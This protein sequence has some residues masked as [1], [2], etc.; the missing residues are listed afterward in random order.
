MSKARQVIEELK[1]LSEAAL[2]L[3]AFTSSLE[4]VGGGAHE[5]E[6]V[7]YIF[8]PGAVVA[9]GEAF[10][11][12]NGRLRK[13]NNHVKDG[14]YIRASVNSEGSVECAEGCLWDAKAKVEDG[15]LVVTGYGGEGK[16]KGEAMVAYDGKGRLIDVIHDTLEGIIIETGKGRI[17]EMCANVSPGL[18]TLLKG[19][20]GPSI[21]R[22]K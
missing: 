6:H 1:P 21:V 22:S 17:L 13:M 8:K 3:D 15:K 18:G 20:F 16:T 2:A 9:A 14:I 10:N 12:L 19:V 7:Q 11:H 4:E 5:G